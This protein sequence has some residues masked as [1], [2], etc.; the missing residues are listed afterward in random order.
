MWSIGP[1]R[2]LYVPGAWLKPRNNEV[3]VL[4]LRG[5]KR[6]MLSSRAEPVLDA[7]R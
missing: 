1:Q 3:V 2:T 7:A 4:D 6:P 5:L